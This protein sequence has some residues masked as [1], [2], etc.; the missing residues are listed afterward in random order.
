MDALGTLRR[1]YVLPVFD[2][3]ELCDDHGA[4]VEA[5]LVRNREAKRQ[6]YLRRKDVIL[7]RNKAWRDANPEKQK[8]CMAAWRE[9]NPE[10][11]A[12]TR[13]ASYERNK[14]AVIAR[15][16]ERDAAL[17]DATVRSR[18]CQNSGLQSK[19]VPDQLLPAIRTSM[20][21][22]REIK[23]LKATP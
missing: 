6:E 19:D 2:P 3:F 8:A 5:R 15:Q 12:A 14:D 18:F 16:K 23:K 17:C 22:K 7:A 1:Y 11:K 9:A 4:I 21:I 13:R 10:K 20:L